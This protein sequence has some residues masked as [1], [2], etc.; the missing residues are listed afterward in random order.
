VLANYLEKYSKG[1]TKEISN[2][3]MLSILT[4]PPPLWN[5]LL[6]ETSNLLSIHAEPKDR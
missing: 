3:E 6:D 2:S 5:E 1:E 4:G